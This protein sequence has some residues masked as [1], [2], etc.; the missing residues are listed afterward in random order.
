MRQAEMT[1]ETQETRIHVRLNLDG[2]GEASLSTG[3]GFLDHMLTLL[4]RHAR[5]DL[6]VD[7]LGDLQVDD[8]HTVEDIGIVIGKAIALAL[9]DKRG[10][11]R[12]GQATIPM[13]ETIVQA[14]LDL[15][16]RP[17]LVFQAEFRSDQVGGFSTQ[18][19]AEFFRAL[20]YNAGMTLHLTCPYGSNDH[21]KIE[22]MFKAFARSLRD[23][24]AIDPDHAE[25]IPSTKG[26]L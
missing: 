20:A 2:R 17:Y 12:Y 22:A 9:K 21:H 14:V 6:E 26:V 15:S 23:A 7:A 25:D 4:A 1:R 3:I 5:I 18:M 16:G 10:I 13:D 8:H 19:T 24:A 11:C